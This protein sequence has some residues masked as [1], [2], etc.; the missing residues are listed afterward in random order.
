MKINR[1]AK[2]IQCWECGQMTNTPK[3]WDNN[4]I[5]KSCWTFMKEERKELELHNQNKKG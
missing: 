3:L 2:D 5:C 1:C 4:L